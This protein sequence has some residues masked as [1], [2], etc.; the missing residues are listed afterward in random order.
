MTT[1]RQDQ[2]DVLSRAGVGVLAFLAAVS[3]RLIHVKAMHEKLYFFYPYFDVPV[4]FL[5]GIA[6]ALLFLFIYLIITKAQSS[7]WN[8]REVALTIIFGTLAI[9][10][11]WEIFEYVSGLTTEL[12]YARDTLLD[13]TM[14]VMGSLVVAIAALVQVDHP[15][16][17]RNDSSQ[18]LN[19]EEYQLDENYH[20]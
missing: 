2:R 5:G 6:A 8:E 18:V 3:L 17:K 7:E 20:E 11:G 13:L 15:R 10:I 19:K 1:G 16:R 4:H 12:N 9:G 14:D